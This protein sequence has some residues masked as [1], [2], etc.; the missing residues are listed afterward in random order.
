MS[1]MKGATLYYSRGRKF[2]RMVKVCLVGAVHTTLMLSNYIHI[3]LGL[4]IYDSVLFCIGYCLWGMTFWPSAF[5]WVY[6]MLPITAMNKIEGNALQKRFRPLLIF[7]T[8]IGILGFSLGA[9][10]LGFL[11]SMALYWLRFI[12]GVLGIVCSLMGLIFHRVIGKLA[13]AVKKE[14]DNA[15]TD[16]AKKKR[17]MKMHI[18]HLMI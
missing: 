16:M 10:L 13:K 17:Y 7:N 3:A 6:M 9:I 1:V 11:Q 5:M 4:H 18:I 2:D 12:T 15:K 14:W 8:C